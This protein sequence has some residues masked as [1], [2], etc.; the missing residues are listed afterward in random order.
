[1]FK[2]LGYIKTVLS[3]LFLT[4]IGFCIY[5]VVVFM[6]PYLTPVIKWIKNFLG[7]TDPPIPCGGSCYNEQICDTVLNRCRKN[8]EPGESYYIIGDGGICCNP[9]TH[10]VIDNVCTP[11]CPP[12]KIRCGSADCL[13]PAD[14]ECVNGK[15]CKS[16]FVAVK[17]TANGGIVKQ[18]CGKD[19]NGDQLYPLDGE[20]VSCLGKKCGSN[21][22][23]TKD[24]SDAKDILHPENKHPGTQCVEPDYC[25]D[26]NFVGND[27]VTGKEICCQEK[28]CGE[29]KLCCSGN[30]KCNEA[31]GKC[32][33]KCG[34]EFCPDNS[35]LCVNDKGSLK[36]YPSGC[37]WEQNNYSPPGVYDR[38]GGVQKL[39]STCLVNGNDENSDKP[40]AAVALPGVNT[41]SSD[42]RISLSSSE[43]RE[44]CKTLEACLGKIQQLGTQDAIF[45]DTLSFSR[46][47]D[48]CQGKTNCSILLPTFEKLSGKEYN[49]T[50]SDQRVDGYYD[51]TL[52]P[53]KKEDGTDDV[54]CCY[55]RKTKEFNGYVCPDN[56]SCYNDPFTE[57]QYC[58]KKGDTVPDKH[59]L[60]NCNEVV[61]PKINKNT[62]TCDCP[63]DTYAGTKCQHSL[64][65]CGGNA[66]SIRVNPN[67]DDKY[68]CTCKPGYE[69]ENCENII[70]L[71]G[72]PYNGIRSVICDWCHIVA[73]PGVTL[74]LT[75]SEGTIPYENEDGVLTDLF[76]SSGGDVSVN[77][78][79]TYV[80]KG[81]TVPFGGNVYLKNCTSPLYG[82]Y[83]Q[84]TG[85][86]N[87]SIKSASFGD[88]DAGVVIIGIP[89]PD[90]KVD[91]TK[92][93]RYLDWDKYD[94]P[95]SDVRNTSY[96]KAG[97]VDLTSNQ[98][99]CCKGN[100]SSYGYCAYDQAPC[101]VRDPK[102][103]IVPAA[104][105]GSLPAT[106][107]YYYA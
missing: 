43:T 88:A 70:R 63:L 99:V 89:F 79:A 93:I 12:E 87:Y 26:P 102:N 18:C 74:T 27:D 50:L 4:F 15:I 28:P 76:G 55:D 91:P 36:C 73:G 1:M 14:E 104:N 101:G 81:V 52:C 98:E 6:Q 37:A 41:M 106:G 47:N 78:T 49:Y 32:Q 90:P 86:N 13:N 53:A 9:I 95:A 51:K 60:N 45:A 75:P 94:C 25:C 10:E 103:L 19:N 96:W 16:E 71:E 58:Y 44:R 23:P 105:K 62:L 8:C 38:T 82:Y 7:I 35:D 92:Q 65:K 68:I 46:D 5:K 34:E 2:Y 22:C 42:T 83:P 31:T 3:L 29:N 80:N 64:A 69:G 97:C 30:T 77:Y 85:T 54:N 33:I 24:G 84:I 20:C 107:G 66:S 100:I 40:M 17:E 61:E 59:N 57:N 72:M 56:T 67:D 39:R 11:K 48:V 21:C